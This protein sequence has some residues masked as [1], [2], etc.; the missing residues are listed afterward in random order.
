MSN[1]LKIGLG[2]IAG[3]VANSYFNP[4]QSTKIMGAGK[5]GGP[6]Y[7][8]KTTGP[9]IGSNL[10]GSV[11]NTLGV[12]PFQGTSIG[13]SFAANVPGFIQTG[14][15]N[16]L[17]G[18]GLLGTGKGDAASDEFGMFAGMDRFP[19]AGSVQARSIRTDT[20]FGVSA[21]GNQVPLGRSGR[22]NSALSRPEVQD[23]LARHVRTGVPRRILAAQ[24]SPG[25][26]VSGNV[27]VKRSATRTASYTPNEST[28]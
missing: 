23:F 9:S 4:S 6:S 10:V 12:T 22:V 25:S 28:T 13:K 14:A 5:T 17:S 7:M 19:D 8:F 2:A 3:S 27:G 24:I 21:V 16:L 18:K 1:L 20:N 15:S 26:L 11:M